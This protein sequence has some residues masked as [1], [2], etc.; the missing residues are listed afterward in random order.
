M[1][2]PGIQ[3]IDHYRCI[4]IESMQRGKLCLLEIPTLMAGAPHLHDDFVNATS[5]SGSW[6]GS[7]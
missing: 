2:L 5:V 6:E 1:I 4:H 7:S 3:L